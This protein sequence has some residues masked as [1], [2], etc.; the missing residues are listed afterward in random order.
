MESKAFEY[1]NGIIVCGVCQIGWQR[2]IQDFRECIL[3]ES[4]VIIDVILMNNDIHEQT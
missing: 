2:N 4:V 3:R 1:Q